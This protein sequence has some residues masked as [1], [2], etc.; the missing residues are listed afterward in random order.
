MSQLA[1]CAIASHR[2]LCRERVQEVTAADVI[3]QVAESEEEEVAEE[4]PEE[5]EEEDV[6]RTV[7][8]EGRKRLRKAAE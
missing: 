3:P 5:G 2:Q 1:R 7:L 4:T 8:L 6:A